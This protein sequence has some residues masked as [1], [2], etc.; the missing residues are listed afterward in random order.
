LRRATGGASKPVR[1]AAAEQPEIREGS[2]YGQDDRGQSV[3]IVSRAANRHPDTILH[4]L[5]WH[6]IV[7]ACLVG[8]L[9]MRQAWVFTGMIVY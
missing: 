9:V 1:Q 3:V 5:L 6:S 7:L 4:L 8:L 2:G